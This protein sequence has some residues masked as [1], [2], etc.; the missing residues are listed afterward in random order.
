MK[1]FHY[2]DGELFCEEAAVSEIAREVGT[3]FYLY[4]RKQLEHNYQKIEEALESI[5]HLTCFALKSNANP[6]LLGILAGMNGGAEVVSG[7]E[8]QLAVKSGIDPER[9]VFSGVGKTNREI[10]EAIEN[11][12]FSINIESIEELKIVSQIADRLGR[13]ARIAIRINP[14]IDAKTH[15]YIATG[16]RESKFG[17]D[18]AHTNEAFQLASSLPGIELKGIH[19]HIGSMITEIDPFLKAAQSLVKTVENLK[20]AGISLSHIDIGGGVGID[21]TQ[22]VDAHSTTKSD[23]PDSFSLKKLFSAI[24]PIIQQ[25]GLKLIF[26]PGRLLV[27]DTAVLVTQVLFKKKSDVKN[28][29]VVDAG[30]S[31]LIRPA[32]Y[33]AYHQVVTVKHSSGA[34]EKASIVGPICESGDFLAR[35]RI[36]PKVKRGDLLAITGTGAYGFVLSSNYNGRPKPPEI[37]VEGKS[38]RIIRKRENNAS[39][40]KGTEL[41]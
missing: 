9:I 39:L 4:S 27:G 6:S 32:L 1:P 23:E 19:C 24:L 3:P 17:I 33:D 31:D 26:E 29:T 22:I 37:L 25:T 12:I 14:D 41:E 8:L 11:E 38:H 21:Y 18:S 35:D 5:N 10:E 36:L 28:F 15:P 40:W 13:K 7:G 20:T 2:D 34:T 30:M 16:L